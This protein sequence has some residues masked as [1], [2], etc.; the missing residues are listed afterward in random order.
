MLQ[1]ERGR[2]RMRREDL[3]SIVVSV[4]TGNLC[5]KSSKMDWTVVAIVGILAVIAL[6]ALMHA[7]RS[8]VQGTRT[9]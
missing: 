9:I 6:G 3:A 8:R 7:A 2:T 4:G 1:P 5:E